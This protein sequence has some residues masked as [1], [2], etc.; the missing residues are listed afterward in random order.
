M[1]SLNKLKLVVC[2][3][4]ATLELLLVA[5]LV[6]PETVRIDLIAGG[7]RQLDGARHGL[8]L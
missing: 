6:K 3:R 8:D 5:E 1:L 2:I 7:H 4:E